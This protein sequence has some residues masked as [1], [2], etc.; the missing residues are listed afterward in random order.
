[1]ILTIRITQFINNLQAIRA[2][3]VTRKYLIAN[4]MGE[5]APALSKGADRPR[6]DGCNTTQRRHDNKIEREREGRKCLVK[7]IQK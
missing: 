6:R 5:K 2:N 4:K 7:I 3:K 1:M